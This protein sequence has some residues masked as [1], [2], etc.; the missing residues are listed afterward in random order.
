LKG[1]ADYAEDI[2][3]VHPELST[4]RCW[5]TWSKVSSESVPWVRRQVHL[6]RARRGPSPVGWRPGDRRLCWHPWS[7]PV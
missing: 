2:D 3:S 1:G 4:W 5:A 7:E 6:Q